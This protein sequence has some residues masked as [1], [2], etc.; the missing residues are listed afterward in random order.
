MLRLSSDENF[1]DDVVRGLL[2]R[3]SEL[4]LDRV[5]DDGLTGS[6]DPAILAW[7]ASV[8]R[9]LLTHDRAT[10]P[11]FAYVRLATGE[12]MRGL[13]V[14]NDRLPIRQAIDELL[15]VAMCSEQ[16]EWDGLVLYL[17]L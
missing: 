10:M 13:F 15:I 1:N 4:D 3:V 16:A 2:L 14:L 11:E 9:I 7:S 8:N 17:P 5:R 12:P 6:D